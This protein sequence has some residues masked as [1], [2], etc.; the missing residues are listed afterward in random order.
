MLGQLFQSTGRYS[1]RLHTLSESQTIRTLRD[2]S[3]VVWVCLLDLNEGH[4]TLTVINS[5]EDVTIYVVQTP[6]AR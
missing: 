1:I 6:V 5:S 3:G 2:A 4:G